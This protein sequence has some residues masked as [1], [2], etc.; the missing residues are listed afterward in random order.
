MSDTRTYTATLNRVI[1]GDTYLLDIDLGFWVH[2]AQRIRLRG[3]NAPEITG[4]EKQ[5]GLVAKAAAE[6][7]ISQSQPVTITTHKD[8]RSFER[9]VA[10]VTLADGRNLATVMVEQGQADRE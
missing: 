5:K 6:A 9:W 1:D 4:P 8:E 2:T 7:L 3:V 10:D